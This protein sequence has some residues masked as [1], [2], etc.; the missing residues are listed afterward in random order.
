MAEE[1]PRCV[2]DPKAVCEV[3]KAIQ[4]SRDIRGRVAAVLKPGTD[5]EQAKL[6]EQMMGQMQHVFSDEFA[7]LPKFCELCLRHGLREK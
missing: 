5:S 2:F 1:G 6:F 3:R 4:E 7:T